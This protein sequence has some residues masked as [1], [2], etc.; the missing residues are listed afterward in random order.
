M[1][2]TRKTLW[3]TASLFSFLVFACVTINIYFPAEKVKSAAEEIV[4]EIRGQKTDG[5]QSLLK[6]N[7]LSVSNTL[8]TFLCSRVWAAEALT[9]SNPTIRALKQRMKARYARMRPYYDKGVLRE[10]DDGYVALGNTAGLG[11][12][13]KRDLNSLVSAENSDRK[14]LYQEIAK[15]MNIDPSQ[16]NRIGEI[17][18]KQWQ[19]PVR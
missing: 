8:A 16:V 14:R 6:K 4:D 18:A 3:I 9:V 11:L 1:K 12:K 13:E 2:T 17:F 7:G 19:K 10:K 15:A 5:D